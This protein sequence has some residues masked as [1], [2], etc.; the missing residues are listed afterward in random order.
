MRLSAIQW[1]GVGKL[2][3]GSAFSVVQMEEGTDEDEDE[4]EDD[5]R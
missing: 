4:D 3:R 2:S 5:D 1:S